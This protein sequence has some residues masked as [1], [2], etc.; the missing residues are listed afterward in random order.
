MPFLLVLFLFGIALGVVA[1]ALVHGDGFSAGPLLIGAAL[2][3]VQI[4]LAGAYF[5]WVYRYCVRTG[6]LARYSAE[7]AA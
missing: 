5:Q 2:A 4:L 6:L 3:I 1:S 7:S